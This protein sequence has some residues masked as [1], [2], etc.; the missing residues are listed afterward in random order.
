MIVH[1][2]PLIPALNYP[3]MQG[4]GA[5]QSFQQAVGLEQIMQLAGQD[6]KQ[7]KFRDI[8]M[9]IGRSGGPLV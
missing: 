2:T 6:P 8:L 5:Y 3:I 1:S 4:R 7:V 9:A